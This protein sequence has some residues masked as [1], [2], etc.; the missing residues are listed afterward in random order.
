MGELTLAAGYTLLVVALV[1]MLNFFSS[2]KSLMD[3]IKFFGALMSTENIG[4][5]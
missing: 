3:Y 1:M 5:E 2:D 4:Y